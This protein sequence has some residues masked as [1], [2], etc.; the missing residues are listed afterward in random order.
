[1]K[2]VIMPSETV[3]PKLT[4][5][6]ALGVSTERL[7]AAREELTTQAQQKPFS[8]HPEQ[9]YV[10]LL[11]SPLLMNALV[12]AGYTLDTVSDML[13]SSNKKIFFEVGPDLSE[14]NFKTFLTASNEDLCE[15]CRYA[16]DNVK[17]RVVLVNGCERAGDLCWEC[18]C[19]VSGKTVKGAGR[20]ACNF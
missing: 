9:C 12:M 3:S 15:R 5:R 11:V 2:G 7:G 14:Y 20:W 10:F 4:Y 16:N 18:A 19:I 8:R 13:Y 6:E 1:M 17:H